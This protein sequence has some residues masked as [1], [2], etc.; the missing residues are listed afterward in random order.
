M[1][2]E[3][4]NENY[5]L[6]ERYF[7]LLNNS[8]STL[9]DLKSFLHNEIVW[10]EM[11]N[12]F[13]PTGRINKYDEIMT[14]WE[15]GR[16]FLPQQKFILRRAIVSAD[17]AVLEFSWRGIISKTLAGLSAGTELSGHVASVLQFRDGQ[18]VSQTDYPCYDPIPNGAA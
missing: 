9:R 5:H 12:R 8:A 2:T 10:Q 17:I 13:A 18:I 16:E 3:Q 7:E 4:E 11:P 14:T 15:K 6:V 1:A